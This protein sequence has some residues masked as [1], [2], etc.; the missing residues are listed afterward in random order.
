MCAF[1]EIGLP[2]KVLSLDF[3]PSEINSHFLL[4]WD[5]QSIIC[6]VGKY[7]WLP[8]WSSKVKSSKKK[9]SLI[10]DQMWH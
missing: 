3:L 9:K 8:F 4:L 1:A 6:S 2:I 5:E 7:F 10:E